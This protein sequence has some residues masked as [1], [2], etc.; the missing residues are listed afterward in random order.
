MAKK[1]NGYVVNHGGW[2]EFDQA[3]DDNGPWVPCTM[4]IADKAHEPVFTETEVKAIM[5]KMN[6]GFEAEMRT[7]VQFPGHLE[8]DESVVHDMLDEAC[9]AFGITLDPA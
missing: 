7:S 2:I 5:Q 8:V 4:V 9:E 1:V 6:D 3:P